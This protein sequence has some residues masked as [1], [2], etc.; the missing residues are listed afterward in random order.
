MGNTVP[1]PWVPYFSLLLSVWALD[2]RSFGKMDPDPHQR[3][4][5]DTD[6][7]PHQSEKQDPVPHP[8]EKMEAW[9]S[10][11]GALEGPNLGKTKF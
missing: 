2:P 6:P 7:N 8:I 10:H 11:F 1:V 4:K 5:L 3:G 9:E